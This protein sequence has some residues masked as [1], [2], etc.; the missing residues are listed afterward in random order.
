M[1]EDYPPGMKFEGENMSRSKFTKLPGFP[2]R[3]SGKSKK[4]ISQKYFGSRYENYF[5]SNF[6]WNE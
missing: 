3:K 5:Y 6:G 1:R 4:Q 2:Q